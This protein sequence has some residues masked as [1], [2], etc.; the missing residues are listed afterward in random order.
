[1]IDRAPESNFFASNNRQL[2]SLMSFSETA[3][4]PHWYKFIRP[5]IYF[6]KPFSREK[7][8]GTDPTE[9]T[10]IFLLLKLRISLPGKMSHRIISFFPF[11]YYRFFLGGGLRISLLTL[12]SVFWNVLEGEGK[13]SFSGW[14]KNIFSMRP[15]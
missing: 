1:M 7:N 9:I 4:N 13:K 8:L 5:R 11:F 2:D 6:R 10:F 12:S 15:C 3:W 14:M